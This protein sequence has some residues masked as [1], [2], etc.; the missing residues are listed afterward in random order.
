[1]VSSSPQ[2]LA[3]VIGVLSSTTSYMSGRTASSSS[4][5]SQTILVK[6]LRTRNSLT[7]IQVD[8]KTHTVLINRRPQ[9][10]I[11][12]AISTNRRSDI[13]P[14]RPINQHS[15]NELLFHNRH[16]PIEKFLIHSV[17]VHRE[18]MLVHIHSVTTKRHILVQLTINLSATVVHNIERH[19]RITRKRVE[20]LNILNRAQKSQTSLVKLQG[21][22]RHFSLP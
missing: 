9:R 5:L 7:P 16:K 4:V 21:P 10:G 15:T 20:N 14:I 1:M 13:H 6:T 17:H 12:I 2:H 22:I 11:V 3:C 19:L 18:R 8:I